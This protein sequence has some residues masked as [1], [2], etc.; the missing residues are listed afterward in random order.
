[1]LEQVVAIR[2]HVG[3]LWR[4]WGHSLPGSQQPQLR[5]QIQQRATHPFH[6][7]RQRI[8]GAGPIYRPDPD[9]RERGLGELAKPAAYRVVSFF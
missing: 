7:R 5:R 3:Q 9:L 6:I 8:D 4:N 2:T 1:M